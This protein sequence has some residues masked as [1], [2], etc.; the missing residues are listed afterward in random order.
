MFFLFLQSLVDSSIAVGH[1][2]SGST[3]SSI[4][5]TPAMTR[6]HDPHGRGG[7][8]NPHPCVSYRCRV[9]YI[10]AHGLRVAAVVDLHGAKGAKAPST[11][12]KSM[13]QPLML[14]A[15]IFIHRH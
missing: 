13:D 15:I 4:T 1:T 8:T 2:A 9:G 7:C 11:A 10:I 6:G 14:H 5:L 12:C 3:S